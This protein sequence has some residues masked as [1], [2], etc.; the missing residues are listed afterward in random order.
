[1]DGDGAR[2]RRLLVRD[3]GE[4]RRREAALQPGDVLL[5][6]LHRRVDAVGDPACAQEASRAG[7]STANPAASRIPAGHPEGYFEAFGE[8]YRDFA[9]AWRGGDSTAMPGLLD[10]LEGMAFIEAVISSHRQNARW[11]RLDQP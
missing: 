4:Q 8:L 5:L 9:R 10:G 2:V 1:M 3:I 6:R 11:V 7:I